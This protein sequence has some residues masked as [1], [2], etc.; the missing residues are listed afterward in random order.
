[1][2][3]DGRGLTIVNEDSKATANLRAPFSLWEKGWGRGA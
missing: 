2:R 3:R 1:M